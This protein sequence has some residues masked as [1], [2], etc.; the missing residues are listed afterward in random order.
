MGFFK[1]KNIF[2]LSVLFSKLCFADSGDEYWKEYEREHDNNPRYGVINHVDSLLQSS[3]G[4]SLQIALYFSGRIKKDS[5]DIVETYQAQHGTRARS[6]EI[7]THLDVAQRLFD[8]ANKPL[9]VFFHPTNAQDAFANF[10]HGLIQE[11]AKGGKK[12][13]VSGF[14]ESE[15]LTI[16]TAES[17]A[18]WNNPEFKNIIASLLPAS[19]P[20]ATAGALLQGTHDIF[21]RGVQLLEEASGVK[22]TVS[23]IME[24]I[25]FRHPS[26]VAFIGYRSFVTSLA[27][28]YVSREYNMSLGGL[29]LHKTPI[30]WSSRNTLLPRITVMS[31]PDLEGAGNAYRALQHVLAGTLGL[32]DFSDLSYNHVQYLVKSLEKSASKPELKRVESILGTVVSADHEF[33]LECM[34]AL[35]DIVPGGKL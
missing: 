30:L 33:Y 32:Q 10:F 1:I 18:W 16:N 26:K 21:D 27:A 13:W 7:S 11:E 17:D 12:K 19:N 34:K 24:K 25:N 6:T 4:L 20:H 5:A 29:F 35:M 15:R 2:L 14:Y 9:F 3:K 31:K 8:E 22:D 28:N 23:G